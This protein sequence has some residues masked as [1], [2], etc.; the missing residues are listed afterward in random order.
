MR[1]VVFFLLLFPVLLHA[2]EEEKYLQ[3]AVTLEDG[4]VVFQKELSNEERS[5]EEIFNSIC[6]WMNERFSRDGCNFV[7]KDSEKGDAA[8]IGEEY[9]EF[10][11]TA[12]SLDRARMSYTVTAHIDGH[13]CLVKLKNIRYEYDV[14][15]Q[16]APERYTAEE[17]ITDEHALYKGKLNRVSGKFRRATIDFTDELFDGFY[18]AMGLSDTPKQ[19]TLQPQTEPTLEGYQ[20]FTPE[21]LPSIMKSMLSESLCDIECAGT[22]LRVEW[23]GMETANGKY[24]A[25]FAISNDD[26]KQ[27]TINDGDTYTLAFSQSDNSTEKWLLIECSKSGSVIDNEMTIVSGDITAIWVK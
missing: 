21:K 2:Q 24:T 20:H 17:W 15:Y 13:S 22:S 4:K 27:L 25:S 16:R 5:R 18:A 12:F 19:V 9:I 7:Y 14:S 23:K 10:S 3:G 11:R 6:D 8:S 1:K 26:A